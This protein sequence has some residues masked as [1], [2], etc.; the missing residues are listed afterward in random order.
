M[1]RKLRLLCRSENWMAVL[2][3]ESHGET[4]RQLLPLQHRSGKN[5]TSDKWW[6]FRFSG[7]NSRKSTG[8]VDRT[9]THKTHLCTTVW[10]QART[11]HSMRLGQ[12]Q[13][14]FA[15]I[16]VRQSKCCHL[17]W[18][19]VSSTV[20]PT[21]ACFHEHFLFFSYQSYHTPRALRTSR[22]SPSSLGR[23][24]APSRITLAWRPAEW[25]KTTHHSSHRRKKS[26]LEEKVQIRHVH[27]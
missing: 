16:F 25:R 3:R 26:T 27:S 8:C 1:R 7:R 15:S 9:P 6:W 18:P 5:S 23:Q 12:D 14:W 10:S 17:V 21:R 22:T 24:V 2:Q 13:A 4:R 19:H 11:A 20:E